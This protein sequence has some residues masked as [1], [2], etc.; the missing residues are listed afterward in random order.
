[1]N[2]SPSWV[3]FLEKAGFDATHWSQVGSPAAPD[4]ELMAWARKNGQVVFTHDM[5]FGALLAATRAR[6]PSVLQ[7]RVKDTLPASLG[8]DVVRVL[9]L[10]REPL[11]KGALVTIEKSRSRVRVLPLGTDQSDEASRAERTVDP[12]YVLL[13]QD[14]PRVE[15]YRRTE[16]SRWELSEARA[17]ETVEVEAIGAA[18]SVDAIYQDLLSESSGV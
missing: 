2:L 3:P 15:V 1:M 17:G 7:A 18:L 8:N 5:D 10:R 14:E 16:S 12:W 11:E 13:A 6:G 4:S 9:T